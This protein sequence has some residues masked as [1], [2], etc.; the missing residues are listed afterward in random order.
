MQGRVPGQYEHIAEFIAEVG[1][2]MMAVQ[3]AA[4]KEDP[5][6]WEALKERFESETGEKLPE[7]FG[8]D[9]L[10]PRRYR[11]SANP[12][13]AVAL[14]FTGVELVARIVAD[15]GW[16]FMV[17]K[18]PYYFITSDYPFGI[19]DPRTDGT[20]YGPAL[21]SPTTEVSFPLTRTIALL[22]GGEITGTQWADVSE[23]LVRQINTRTAMRA[24]FLVS[25]KP[26]A[27]G[28]RTN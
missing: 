28:L 21:A 7:G 2:T 11:I 5:R 10:D 9:D 4:M 27:R 12:K 25:P 13:V 24:S 19:Y 16:R 18:P 1:R 17:S 15:K 23:R 6:R 8:P 3:A 22:A 26:D 14:S 20:I